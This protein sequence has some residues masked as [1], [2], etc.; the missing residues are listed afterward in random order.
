MRTPLR[1]LSLCGIS[2]AT[3][4]REIHRDS[5]TETALQPPGTPGAPK[6]QEI[7]NNLE[8]QYSRTSAF[9]QG[10][11]IRFTAYRSKRLELPKHLLRLRVQFVLL[12]GRRLR[13]RWSVCWSIRQLTTDIEADLRQHL[14]DDSVG[15]LIYTLP[16]ELQGQMNDAVNKGVGQKRKTTYIYCISLRKSTIV[17]QAGH[18]VQI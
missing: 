15:L 11:S 5:L 8:Q 16:V 12:L 14:V 3:E 9:R 13:G 1:N 17:C 18:E 4:G 10:A 6:G 7:P 2:L